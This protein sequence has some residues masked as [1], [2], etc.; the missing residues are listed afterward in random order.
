MKILEVI[1]EHR[2]LFVLSIVLYMIEATVALNT[3]DILN[4]EMF[5]GLVNIVYISLCF[6]LLIFCPAVCIGFLISDFAWKVV[7]N[8]GFML[9]A[10]I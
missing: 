7:K 8:N 10:K 6:F 4:E 5:Y 2:S 9:G 3:E 1:S